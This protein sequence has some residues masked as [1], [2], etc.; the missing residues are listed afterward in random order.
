MQYILLLIAVL[1]AG[2]I[3]GE[4]VNRPVVN[5]YK[6][7]EED[8]EVRTQAIYGTAVEVIEESGDWSKIKTQDGVDGWLSTAQIAKN[9]AYELSENVRPTQSLFTH[10]YRVTDTT[11][12]PP[13]LTLP[14]GSKVLLAYP[15][16]TGER[17]VAI[18]LISGEKAWIHRGDVNFTPRTKTLDEMIAFSANFL[19][20]PYTWAGT[21]TFGFDCSGFVQMLFKEIGVLLPRGSRSQVASNLLAPIEREDLQPGDLVYFGK[22]RIN[23]VGLYLGNDRFIHSGVGEFPRVMISDMNNEKYLFQTARRLKA[24]YLEAETG[25][26]LANP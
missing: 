22:P 13:I 20:L 12:Y 7:A 21:S 16:D 8:T 24:E 14:Y 4:L 2:Q 15:V 18:E 19:G 10:I 11:P 26:H 1:R 17:W 23:H 3:C 5:I 9:L 25:H 6:V